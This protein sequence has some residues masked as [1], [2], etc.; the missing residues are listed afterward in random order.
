MLPNGSY[1]APDTD[2]QANHDHRP[3]SGSYVCVCACVWVCVCVWTWLSHCPSKGDEVN[4]NDNVGERE[5]Q[6]KAMIR[7]IMEEEEEIDMVVGY[8][9]MGEVV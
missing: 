3:A 2:R 1:L 9:V 6:E 4:E 7:K 5:M 8:V